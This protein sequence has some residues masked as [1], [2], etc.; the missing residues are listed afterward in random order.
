MIS[1]VIKAHTYVCIIYVCCVSFRSRI[2]SR[3]VFFLLVVVAHHILTLLRDMNGIVIAT[4]LILARSTEKGER[5]GSYL[6]KTYGRSRISDH[7]RVRV[8]LRFMYLHHTYRQEG[9]AF[10][11]TAR[12]PLRVSDIYPHDL[13]VFRHTHTLYVHRF[14]TAAHGRSTCDVH[15]I[16]AIGSYICEKYSI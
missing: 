4:W 16:R 6:Y 9:N 3:S 10:F 1:F 5:D 8:H 12:I 15:H 13:T 2:P 11:E 14:R 7:A